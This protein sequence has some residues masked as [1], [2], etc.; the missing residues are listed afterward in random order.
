MTSKLTVQ[1]EKGKPPHKG[2][3]AL[4]VFN[5]TIKGP[6]APAVKARRVTQA[7]ESEGSSASLSP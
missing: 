6:R 5:D 2:G 4:F 3:G 7:D 1:T